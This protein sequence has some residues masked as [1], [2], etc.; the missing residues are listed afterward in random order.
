[1]W[2]IGEISW[3]TKRIAIQNKTGN[4]HDVVDE[5]NN[6]LNSSLPNDWIFPEFNIVLAPPYYMIE[7]SNLFELVEIN[8]AAWLYV[9]VP[10]CEELKT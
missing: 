1:M 5:A 10:A 7:D 2:K 9:I 6:C 8:P 4:T 3:N